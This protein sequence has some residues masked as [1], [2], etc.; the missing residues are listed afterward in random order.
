MSQYT[1]KTRKSAGRSCMCFT[2]WHYDYYLIINLLNNYY[3]NNYLLNTKLTK[4]YNFIF[5][6]S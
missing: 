1:L 2:S 6:M 4:Y 3:L 5:N